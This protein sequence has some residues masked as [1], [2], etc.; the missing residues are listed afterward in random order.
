M[1]AS[2]WLP[3]LL[4]L[5]LVVYAAYIFPTIRLASTIA[6][7]GPSDSALADIASK[8]AI[9]RLRSV[10]K[11]PRIKGDTNIETHGSFGLID[12]PQDVMRQGIHLVHRYSFQGE[13]SIGAIDLWQSSHN[14]PGRGWLEYPREPDERPIFLR[15]DG[16]YSRHRVENGIDG[17]FRMSTVGVIDCDMKREVVRVDTQFF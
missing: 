10:I 9:R 4:I 17:F 16:D 3:C 1:R 13:G 8:G 15:V 12:R 2:R 11:L 7:R 14:R 6:R 5:P